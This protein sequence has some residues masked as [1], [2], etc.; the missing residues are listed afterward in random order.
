[1]FLTPLELAGLPDPDLWVIAEPLR[2]L[3]VAGELIEVPKGFITDLA[4]IPHFVDWIPFLDRTGPSRRPGALH[5]WLYAGMRSKGKAWA[6][7]LLR[8]ALLAEGM[9]TGSAQT[10]YLAVHWFGGPSYASDGR[11]HPY[12]EHPGHL[13]SND[14]LTEADWLAWKNSIPGIVALK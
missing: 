10:Y 5:D 4:S 2:Y 8:E 7:S 9:S 3:S 6:D 14:F 13:E 1:M 12:A 11:R